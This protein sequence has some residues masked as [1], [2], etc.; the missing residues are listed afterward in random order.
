[1]MDVHELAEV[2]LYD[3]LEVHPNAE[4]S[5]IK[6][7]YK[8]LALKHHPDKDPES[9]D[10]FELITL[11]YNILGDDAT[12]RAYDEARSRRNEWD[13][14]RLKEG[15]MSGA[16]PIQ[17]YGPEEVRAFQ[18]RMAEMDAK[19]GANLH[20]TQPK[21]EA[22]QSVRKQLEDELLQQ[23]PVD[24][25]TYFEGVDR[26]G[27]TEQATDLVPFNDG[28]ILLNGL[29]QID[30]LYDVGPPEIEDRFRLQSMGTFKEDTTSLDER[31]ENYKKEGNQWKIV[32]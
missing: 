17:P 24:L 23:K 19:H 28:L 29:N 31:M 11:A 6:R 32:S 26:G 18:Q 5:D 21:L 8:R 22:I 20:A 2:D 3:I 10:R 14:S 9:G 12:R 7:Q 4:A 27:I 16:K 15:A 30:N 13:F 25:K 1:M